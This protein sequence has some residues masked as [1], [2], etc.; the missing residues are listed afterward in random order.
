MP[1]KRAVLAEEKLNIGFRIGERPPS[2]AV[3]L[4]RGF[5]VFDRLSMQYNCIPVR[6]SI[7]DPIEKKM[8]ETNVG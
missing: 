6:P 3:I 5:P 1:C 7:F 4:S 8:D 2:S